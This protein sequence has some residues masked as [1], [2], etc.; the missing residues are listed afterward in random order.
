METPEPDPR[1]LIESSLEVAEELL[2]ERKY[3]AAEQVLRGCLPSIPTTAYEARVRW[4]SLILLFPRGRFSGE[5][6]DHAVE[7]ASYIIQHRKTFSPEVQLLAHVVFHTLVPSGKSVDREHNELLALMVAK[8]ELERTSEN[9]KVRNLAL[10]LTVLVAEKGESERCLTELCEKG[11]GFSLS[12]ACCEMDNRFHRDTELRYID[13]AIQRLWGVE[14]LYASKLLIKKMNVLLDILSAHST[15]ERGEAFEKIRPSLLMCQVNLQILSG[16]ELDR[17]FA[18]YYLGCI[19]HCMGNMDM[20]Q[21]HLEVAMAMAVQC[22]LPK[23]S[24]AARTLRDTIRDQ[25]RGERSG[26]VD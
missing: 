8:E 22:D 24:D 14:P 23:L 10:L 17:A 2:R 26:E 13:R 3:E 6:R 9:R 7:A 25:R 11:D 15:E 16:N 5:G 20:A 4:Y 18:E 12:L 21:F 19:A 1:A